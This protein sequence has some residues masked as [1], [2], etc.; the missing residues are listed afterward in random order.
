M[1]I[2][3]V[4]QTYTKTNLLSQ[5]S[6]SLLR[7]TPMTAA[8][9]ATRSRT[10]AASDAPSVENSKP[11]VIAKRRNAKGKAKAKEED[12]AAVEKEPE[13][14]AVLEEEPEDSI[15]VKKEPEDAIIVKEEPEDATL[16]VVKEELDDATVPK[17]EPQ[18]ATM[19]KE[20]PEDA[21]FVKEEPNDATSDNATADTTT[22]YVFL[23]TTSQWKSVVR[24]EHKELRELSKRPAKWLRYIG[25]GVYGAPGR[26][27]RS[28]DS[29]SP[30][31]PVNAGADPDTD[32]G[33]PALPAVCY[34]ISQDEPHYID[35]EMLTDRGGTSAQS[36]TSDTLFH[37]RIWKRDRRCVFMQASPNPE[38]RMMRSVDCESAHIVPHHKGREYLDIMDDKHNV[39][40]HQRLHGIDDPRNGMFLWADLRKA[41]G[42]GECAFLLVSRLPR[43][44][45]LDKS[46]VQVPNPYMDVGDVHEGAVN[47]EH[48]HGIPDQ[49]GTF[50]EL[51]ERELEGA[52]NEEDD[53]Y[54]VSER[55]TVPCPKG[56]A[57]EMA[58]KTEA[59]ESSIP[60]ASATLDR[61]MTDDSRLVL[62]WVGYYTSPI[63]TSSIPNNTHATLRRGT[64]LYTPGLHRAY[65]C[66]AINRW[67][68]DLPDAP[69]R[70]PPTAAQQMR[71]RDAQRWGRSPRFSSL[72]HSFIDPTV[73]AEYYP[74]RGAQ[75]ERPKNDS[76]SAYEPTA[77]PRQREPDWAWQPMLRIDDA[78]ALMKEVMEAAV[79]QHRMQRQEQI[80][81][82]KV[83]Q[84]IRRGTIG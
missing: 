35:L 33:A 46:F 16:P 28:D 41:F 81:K 73:R 14:A 48:P 20:E 22:L 26:L 3:D 58:V 47:R 6:P 45:M 72:A 51:E 18:D 55:S 69:A 40:E 19:V 30:E 82:A 61:E 67:G 31:I 49:D 11:A 63:V 79:F 68:R 21:I 15:V 74:V 62:Q 12:V 32:P 60:Q 59:G 17:K 80:G 9:R 24:V 78:E 65:A 13:D 77:A 27:H 52:M 84:W 76:A 57:T 83:A 64:Q 8:T 34:Y 53:D 56:E 1:A 38:V 50:N 70:P 25:W 44:A 42:A 66:A 2:T 75:N 39:L 36:N 43:R 5:H 54:S 7:T 23:N 71:V 37:R 4:R 29:T 10:R